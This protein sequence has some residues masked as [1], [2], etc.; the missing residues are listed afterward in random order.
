MV[1]FKFKGINGRAIILNLD[2]P[3]IKEQL[4]K[5]KGGTAEIKYRFKD[6]TEEEVYEYCETN[7][8]LAIEKG[9]IGKFFDRLFDTGE[10]Y[11]ITNSFRK[12]VKNSAHSVEMG[13]E[14]KYNSLMNKIQVNYSMK[15]IKIKREVVEAEEEEEN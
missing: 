15:K 3:F 10:A 4:I 11:V 12:I 2:E 1:K 6:E 8:H 9:N 5:K 13:D 14:E 7:K